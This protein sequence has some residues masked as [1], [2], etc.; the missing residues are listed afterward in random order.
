MKVLISGGAGFIGSHTADLL[1]ERGHDVRILDALLPPVHAE[2]RRPA[3]LVGKDVEWLE[4]D[5]RDRDAW[6]AAL[7]GVDAVFHLADYQDL[8]PDFSTFFSTNTTSTALLYEMLVE[9][10][11]AVNKVVIGSSQAVYG[12]GAYRCPA[13][14]RQG[15]VRPR[16]RSLLQ[17]RRRQ[18][19]IACPRCAGN[20]E[21][22]KVDENAVAPHNAYAVSKY[23]QEMA[24]L[25]LGRRYGIPTVALRYSIVQGSRQSF[26]NAYSGVLR[27]FTQRLLHDKRAVCFEDGRQLRDYV[28]VHDVARAN[29]LV[30]EDPRA[31]GRVFN[32][33]SGRPVSVRDIAEL[34]ARTTRV[35]MS[36]ETSGE[37]RFGDTRHVIPDIARLGALGWRPCVPLEDI[38]REYVAW[39]TSEPGFADYSADANDRMVAVGAIRRSDG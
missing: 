4:G 16:P 35:Y 21:P 30:L 38:V 8:L 13:C 22:V 15:V 36:T 5:V 29:V 14:P 18:W 11:A 23:A 3:Y 19:E 2:R 20:M 1:L 34:V 37:F 28:S 6:R 10:G 12:E 33:G 25:V 39:A 24:A 26:R 9:T 27:I 7:N 32:V 17:L 31:D